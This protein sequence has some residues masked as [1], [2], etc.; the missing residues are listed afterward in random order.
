LVHLAPS[1]EKRRLHALPRNDPDHPL[2]GGSSHVR[3]VVSIPR[4]GQGRG[5]LEYVFEAGEQN[6]PNAVTKEKAAEIAAEI[7]PMRIIEKL[8]FM[9]I[10]IDI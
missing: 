4:R 7:L 8:A 3:R 2:A 6:S 1:L 5:T 10:P 9:V